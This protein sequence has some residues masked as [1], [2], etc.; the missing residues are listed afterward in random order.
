MIALWLSLTACDGFRFTRETAARAPDTSL[1][2]AL[3]AAG[4]WD[5]WG[6]GRAE[7]DG[8]RLIT[9]R[10][11]AIRRGEAVQIWV[12]ETFTEGQRVK[13]DG[14]HPDEFPVMKLND[15]RHFQTGIYDYHVL[16]ST[17]QRLDGRDPVGR[18]TKV[19]LSVQE[20]CGHAWEE[21]IAGKDG[22]RR[23]RRSYFDGENDL[24]VAVEVP[25]DGQLADA[26]AFVARGLPAELPPGE[27]DWIGSALDSRF[28]HEDGVWTRAT[29]TRGAAEDVTVPAGTFRAV[30]VTVTPKQGVGT[31]WY[32]EEQEPRRI[33]KWTRPN[34]EIAELT[35][36]IRAPYWEQ[37]GE[38]FERMRAELGLGDPS[39]LAP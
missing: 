13:S 18:P 12:T 4:F 35:G 1:P 36:S 20:W 10:Y 24:D 14:G 37:N 25:S 21:W 30:P 15:V 38:G 9:P 6:D 31:T 2:P 29:W 8:Y 23:M 19:T 7:L 28:A 33:V 17:F 34:G 39:W 16:T 11:G 22:Y 5:R 3:P 26:G 27:V 32:V